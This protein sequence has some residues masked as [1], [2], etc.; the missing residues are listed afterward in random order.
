[1]VIVVTGL[2]GFLKAVVDK[3]EHGS[4]T[5][6]YQII[7]PIVLL[8]S[9]VSVRLCACAHVCVLYV[10]VRTY[11]CVYVHACVCLSVRVS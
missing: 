11:I 1:M 5:P 9:A 4:E 2:C 8:L 3:I 6:N 7:S 10:C